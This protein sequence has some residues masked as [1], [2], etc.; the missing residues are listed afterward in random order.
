[1]TWLTCSSV[2]YTNFTTYLLRNLNGLDHLDDL[3]I[4]GNKIGN[5]RIHW[6]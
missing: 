5:I 4:V 2:R 3:D 6:H 1:L